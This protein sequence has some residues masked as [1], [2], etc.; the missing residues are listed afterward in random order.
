MP[1]FD[2]ILFDF[3]GVLVDS[4]PLHCAAWAEV[5][6]PLGVRLDWEYYRKHYLGIEDGDMIRRI[7]ARAH[8]P[9]D[10]RDLWACHAAKKEILRHKLDHAPFAPGLARLLAD[11]QRS[12][13]LAVVSS[14]ARMEVEPPLETAGLRG[15][16]AAVVTGQD[17]ARPKPSP[18]PYLLAARLVSSRTPLVVEDS[19]AGI[20][21]GRAA[22][23]EVMAVANAAEVPHLLRERLSSGF[24]PG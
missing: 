6:A 11:L 19:P 24:A 13:Q 4:E 21:S 7:A 18:D 22:G 23:F 16:F 15:Y 17:V 2:A 3:D 10:W 1:P 8:P 20:A 5:L 12:Y 9:L 14:S